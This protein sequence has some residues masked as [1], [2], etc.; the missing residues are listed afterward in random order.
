MGKV[1]E[2]KVQGS[3]FNVERYTLNIALASLALLLLFACGGKGGPEEV[4]VE[5]MDRYYVR[6]NLQEAEA[7]VS[8]LAAQKIQEELKL[9]AGVVS[10]AQTRSREVAYALKEKREGGDRAFFVYEVTITAKGV[11]SFKKKSI[12]S[13]GRIDGIWRIT[14]FRDFDA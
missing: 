5:F 3:R 13:L 12:L 4:A 1:R 11:G 7:L 2:F 14:N 9:I 8:G 10:D 6:A